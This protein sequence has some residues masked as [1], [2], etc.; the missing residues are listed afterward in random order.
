[1]ARE[2]KHLEKM[3]EGTT[4]EKRSEALECSAER[5]GPGLQRPVKATV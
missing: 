2:S 3:A 4:S 5:E 1:M